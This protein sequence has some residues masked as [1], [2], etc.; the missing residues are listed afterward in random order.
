MQRGQLKNAIILFQHECNY[1]ICTNNIYRK[2]KTN[3]IHLK[4]I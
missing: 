1:I 4:D 2:S 3:N